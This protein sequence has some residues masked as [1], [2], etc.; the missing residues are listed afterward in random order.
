MAK[1]FKPDVGS[2]V[3]KKDAQDWIDKYDRER[4]K[5]K[6]HDTKSVFYG[7]DALLRLLAEDGSTGITF[8]FALKPDEETKKDRVQLVLVP[9][10]EDGTLIWDDGA[11]E[12]TST[13]SATSAPDSSSGP[14]DNG[15]MCPPNCS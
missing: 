11:V 13:L 2:K 1:K 7:R 4:R 3:S 15:L 9:T 8:F 14:V 10:R 6:N 12:K 5:D